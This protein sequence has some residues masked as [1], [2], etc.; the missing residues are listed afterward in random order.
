M[1]L[2]HIEKKALT[3]TRVSERRRRRVK[4]ILLA[5]LLIMT[6]TVIYITIRF[7]QRGLAKL[8]A[9]VVKGERYHEALVKEPETARH[10]PR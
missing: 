3:C 10:F 9:L 2:Y 6:G 5:V 4:G 8:H 7:F 1:S